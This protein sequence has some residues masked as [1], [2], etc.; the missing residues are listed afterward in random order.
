[1]LCLLLSG[2]GLKEYPNSHQLKYFS[3]FEK[4]PDDITCGI[5]SYT[6]IVPNGGK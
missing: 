1:M 2:C 3:K 4:Q 5:Y 6:M